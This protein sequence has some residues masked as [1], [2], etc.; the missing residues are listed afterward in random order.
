MY[1]V[2]DEA[3]QSL[4]TLASRGYDRSGEGSE[5]R[6]GQGLIGQAAASR[7]C[8]LVNS[9]ALDRAYAEAIQSSVGQGA[10]G[11]QVQWPGLGKPM[12][13]IAVPLVADNELLGVLYLESPEAFRF[14]AADER[15]LKIAANQAASAFLRLRGGAQPEEAGAPP[16]AAV[17]A[18]R[19][20]LQIVYVPHAEAIF[21]DGQY[22]IKN[23]PARILWKLLQAWRKG[24]VEFQNKAL[25]ADLALGLPEL[26]DNLE[27]RLILLRKRLA[28]LCPELRLVPTTRGCFRLE[29][30]AKLKLSEKP[31]P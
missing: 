8:V 13:Q 3:G 10:D 11:L 7:Q 6:I 30:D 24:Q 18:P 22:L 16:V 5:I 29:V 4:Y 19:A 21:V 14:R 17:R 23:V 31:G 26:K 1:L 9:A 25:R 20:E 2:P 15:V 28:A 27:S 12:S